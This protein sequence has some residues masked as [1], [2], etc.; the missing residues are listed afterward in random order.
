MD[1]FWEDRKHYLR[2]SLQTIIADLLL[3]LIRMIIDAHVHI[4]TYTDKGK[5]LDEATM[6]LL[7]E[8]N[9]NN[10]DYA[11]VI[12][13]NL[14]NDPKI[15]DLEAT[16]KII[17]NEK[18][19]FALGSPQIIQ[20]GSSE[21][22]KYRKLLKEG[23][24]KGLKFFPGHDPY[25]PTDE[26]CLPYYEL[27]Q[28]LDY[29]VVIHTGEVSSDPNISNPMKYN[30]PKYIVEIAK[31]FPNLKVVIAH[32]YWP[33][34]EYCYGITREVPNIYFEISGCADD[35][36]IKASGGMEKMVSI[37]RKTVSDRPDKVIFGTD[38]PLCDSKT[39]SGFKKHIDL[40]KSLGLGEETE[41]LIFWKNANKIY[42]LGLVIKKLK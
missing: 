11:V 34:I 13:D 38:W 20:R 26:R 15:A 5:N 2:D 14:E 3:N 6:I 25:N 27:L 42:K 12:P 7:D 33:K 24:I 18:R 30:D 16:L 37:L 29:P 40:V 23:T 31:E 4:L 28:E 9:S 19:L 8:M 1:Q 41:Q 39:E 32:Y 10:I 21:I 36:V 17:K 22:G 35:E